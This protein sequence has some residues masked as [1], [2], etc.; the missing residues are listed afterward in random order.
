MSIKPLNYV[1]GPGI[2]N[3]YEVAAVKRELAKIG[4]FLEGFGIRIIGVYTKPRPYGFDFHC[5]KPEA[6]LALARSKAAFAEDDTHTAEGSFMAGETHGAGF[7]QIGRGPR[8]HLEIGL[9]GKCNVHIDSHGFVMGKGN[10]D[11]NLALEHG[12][13]DLL[14][15]KAPGLFGSFGKQGQVGAMVRPMKGVD[16][17][18]RWVVGLTGH[19]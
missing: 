2:E 11:Y 19:W 15:D 17:K 1:T 9:D 7:R 6:L 10:Y 12:Y 4:I 13:W 14:S 16:G 3:R 18:M 8:L 5:D